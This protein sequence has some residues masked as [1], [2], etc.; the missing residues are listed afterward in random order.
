[1]TYDPFSP[2]AAESFLE[3][4]ATA[5]KWPQVGYIVEGTVTGYSMQ[6]QTDYDSGEPLFWVGNSRVEQSKTDVHTKPVMQMLLEI[7]G[8]PTGETWEGLQNVR[9]TLPDDDGMRTAYVKGALQAAL[10]DALRKAGAKLEVG[11]YVRIERIADGPQPNPKFAAPHRY[12]ATWTPAAQ[13]PNTVSEFLKDDA[14]PF[15]PGQTAPF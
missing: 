1:M 13:N 4:G 11:A 12:A 3:G 14:D 9:K 15:A 6:Q 10:K 2:K 5:A 7:Q 8:R